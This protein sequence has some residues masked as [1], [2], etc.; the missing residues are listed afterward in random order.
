ME[1]ATK[2]SSTCVTIIMILSLSLIGSLLAQ[3]RRAQDPQEEGAA[4]GDSFDHDQKAKMEKERRDDAYRKLKDDSERLYQAAGDLK[5][6]IDKS[7]QHT[8]SLQIIKKTEEIEKI[9]K[10]V[11]RRAKEGS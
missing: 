10:D 8:F 4:A 1:V 11:K 2:K 6:M 7:N 9:L 5:E 3:N